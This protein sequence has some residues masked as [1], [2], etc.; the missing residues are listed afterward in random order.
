MELA[1]EP[2]KL[3]EEGGYEEADEGKTELCLCVYADGTYAVQVDDGDPVKVESLDAAL[4]AI[5]AYASELTRA[6]EIDT[7]KS[8]DAAAA[9]EEAF[10]SGFAGARGGKLGA[11]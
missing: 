9:G 6:P 2:T 8:P 1:K 4:A 10:Q 5:K 7:G 11:M 3:P